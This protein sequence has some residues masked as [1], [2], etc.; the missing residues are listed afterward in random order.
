MFW[1][2]EGKTFTFCDRHVGYFKYLSGPFSYDYPSFVPWAT[3]KSTT[4]PGG[5]GYCSYADNIWAG[6]LPCYRQAD[7][8][9]VNL[10]G[11]NL[12]Q[13]HYPELAAAGARGTAGQCGCGFLRGQPTSASGLCVR[14]QPLESAFPCKRDIVHREL[15]P[16]KERFSSSDESHQVA[17]ERVDYRC[18]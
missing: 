12:P 8:T 6:G 13:Q 5:L 4:K 3:S 7:G 10:P 18:I 11:A 2:N 16:A 17:V 14:L 9:T 1:H 15:V